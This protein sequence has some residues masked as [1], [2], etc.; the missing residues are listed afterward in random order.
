MALLQMFQDLC[1]EIGIQE[2]SLVVSS[3]DRTVKQLLALAYRVGDELLGYEW[4]QLQRQHTIT[5]VPGQEAY[6]LPGDFDR[7]IFDTHWSKSDR[8]KLVGP[9]NPGEWQYVKNAVVGLAYSYR[10]RLKGVGTN[11]FFV[12]PVPTAA[13]AGRELVFEYVSSNW[14]RPRLWTANTIFG[15]GSYCFSDG[16]YYRTTLGGTSGSTAPTPLALNDGGVTWQ[17]YSGLYERFVADTDT[18]LMPE[19]LVALGIQWRFL[20]SKKLEYEELKQE[21]YR[22]VP[23][24]VAKLK[25]AQTLSMVPN[26][27]EVRPFINIPF[28]IPQP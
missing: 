11:Q 15:A 9:L 19:K 22:T 25:G 23:E 5:L 18:T 26:P 3:T 10:Y 28:N 14:L 24:E 8:W 17:V 21:F 20:A 27:T 13:D 12:D 1:N 7:H 4:P 2:P 6:P 16:V